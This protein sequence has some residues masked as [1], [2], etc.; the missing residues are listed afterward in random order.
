[1]QL[2]PMSSVP[3]LLCPQRSE[4][5]QHKSFLFK[6]IK[7]ICL[8]F[9]HQNI[10]IIIIVTIFIIIEAF[11]GFLCWRTSLRSNIIITYYTSCMIPLKDA[12][13]IWLPNLPKMMR[14]G[15]IQ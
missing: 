12:I 14:R 2:S 1:M 3:Q 8:K 15:K 13:Y 6:N 10:N 11:E 4:T 5:K 7:L 9:E